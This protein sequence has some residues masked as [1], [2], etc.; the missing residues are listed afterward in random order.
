MATAAY[1]VS[2]A[3]LISIRC[4][5]LLQRWQAHQL[6]PPAWEPHS[7]QS[8]R[9]QTLCRVACGMQVSD[10]KRMLKKHTTLGC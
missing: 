7:R 9:H 8:P 6:P 10:I 2:F 1:N 3:V 4:W 5:V